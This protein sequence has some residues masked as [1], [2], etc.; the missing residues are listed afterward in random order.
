MEQ[1]LPTVSSQ[2]AFGQLMNKQPDDTLPV[3]RLRNI[4]RI[5]DEFETALKAGT[6]VRPEDYLDK[7][8]EAERST[9]KQELETVELQFHR[10]RASKA[11][12]DSVQKDPGVK[13]FVRTLVASRLMTQAEIDEFRSGLPDDEKPKTAEDLAKALYR[14]RKLT[15]FQTQAVFQGK[16]KGMVVGNYV[17]LDKIGQ[18]GMGHVYKAQHKRM[19]R[20]V[21]LKLLPSHISRQERMV[22][23][24]HR[25][26]VAAARLNHTNIVTAYDADEADGVH[27]LVMELV[28][29]IDLSQLVRNK[30]TVSVAKAIDYITQAAAG[31]QYAHD[32]GVV[33]RDI[34]P[35]NLLL[36]K[37]G[38][39]KILDM[40]LARFE[41]EM[42]ESTAAKSLTQSG[43]VMGTLDYMAPEQALDTHHASAKT[44]SG[45]WRS[46]PTGDSWRPAVR[47]TVGM[48]QSRSGRW[49]VGRSYKPLR[50]TTI[51]CGGLILPRTAASLC[52]GG[53]T[54]SISCGF[55]T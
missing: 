11:A 40:G 23:R 31:L 9:L 37:S 39:V 16:T 8:P 35:A 26:V 18:G 10:E 13:K 44:A 30:G 55:G 3:S 25:E 48:E 5:C 6:T 28:E 19:K 53:P 43:Q 50:H 49:G 47:L 51:T 33:H 32:Q 38:T 15:R 54:E 52:P 21:A 14:H 46:H 29:G 34:K 27:F 12:T 17:V 4:D 36:D 20:E 42:H 41:R 45:L 22:E 1:T 7:V 24:F 2:P